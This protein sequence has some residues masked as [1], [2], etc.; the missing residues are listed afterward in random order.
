MWALREAGVEA[1][2]HRGGF[3]GEAVR[4]WVVEKIVLAAAGY[5]RE[6]PFRFREREFVLR[7]LSVATTLTC[8]MNRIDGALRRRREGDSNTD[9]AWRL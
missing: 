5:W 2:R 7:D 4:V 3:V 8:V 1:P 9:A 6:W